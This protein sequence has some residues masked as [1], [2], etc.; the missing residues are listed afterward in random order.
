MDTHGRRLKN[1]RAIGIV[2]ATAATGLGLLYMSAAGAP[3]IH[4]GVNALSLLM[5]LALFAVIPSTRLASRLPGGVVVAL[6]GLL[7]ATALFGV[8][9][10]GASR[11]IRV[12]GLAM[13][14]SLVVVPA[15]LVVFAR[16]RGLLA[17]IGL[18][19]AALALA[20]QPDRA[21]A[22]VL[23]AALA[24]LAMYRQDRWVASALAAAV[25]GFAVTLIR[26]DSLPAV[27]YVDQVL[28]TAFQVHA[29]VGIAV[30]GGALLLIVPAL[31][32]QW[33]DPKNR[34][35]HAVFG[36]VWLGMVVAAA[37]G[38]YPTPLVGYGGSAI[39]GY[40][41][42]LSFMPSVAPSAVVAGVRAEGVDG[43]DTTPA[44]DL[45][46]GVRCGHTVG[47]ESISTRR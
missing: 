5:G 7:L 15:M 24:A 42:S 10:E 12:G 13:Q 43:T 35:I 16:D 2:C 11:W 37:L 46:I 23:A 28:Y 40:A 39:L 45:R 41:L 25:V 47:F 19:V 8:S 26:S 3:T 4:L 32:G 14:I 17:T 30:V 22:G 38:N 34:D 27:P 33:I 44:P 1:P 18:V 9:V 6:G 20:L 31:A 21:M 29:L 36:T